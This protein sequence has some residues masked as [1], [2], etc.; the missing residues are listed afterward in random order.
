MI[1]RIDE[2]ISKRIPERIL[3]TIDEGIAK[4]IPEDSF[5]E[6][7]EKVPKT[8][9]IPCGHHIIDSSIY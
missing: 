1:E 3:E 2:G 9:K 4:E 7:P 8:P 6:I 5:I